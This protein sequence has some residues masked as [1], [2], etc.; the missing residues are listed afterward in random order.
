M[1]VHGS[2]T[3]PHSLFVSD[4]H[5]WPSRPAITA[6]FIDFLAQRAC[7]A[8]ALY[9]LGDLFEYWAGDDDLDEAHHRSVI[10]ALAACAASGTRIYFMHGNRDFLI[11]RRFAE[12]AQ[13]TLLSDPTLLVLYGQRT[14]LSHGDAYCTDDTAYQDF[15]RQ[16]REPSWQAQFLS[17]PLAARKAQIEAIRQRSE[18]EKSQKAEDIMDVNPAAITQLLREHHYPPLFI[19]GHTHRPAMHRHMVDGHLCQRWVLGDWYDQGSCLRV[20]ASGCRNIA[21]SPMPPAP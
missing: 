6:L 16:V 4:L 14:L 2:A 11:A 19:H 5:L 10:D 9:I 21:L 13:A 20:D 7:R 15:R 3:D 8:E 18:Q 1:S 12:A 17:Q